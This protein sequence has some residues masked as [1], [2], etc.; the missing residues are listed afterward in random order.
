MKANYAVISNSKRL[1]F[2]V[3]DD[4]YKLTLNMQH[5]YHVC[6]ILFVV[7]NYDAHSTS[8]TVIVEL[9]IRLLYD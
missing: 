7:W 6:G 8:V 4:I 3:N 9:Y 5:L 1:L 2:V